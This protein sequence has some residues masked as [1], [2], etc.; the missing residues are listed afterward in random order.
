MSL[1]EVGAFAKT[2]ALTVKPDPLSGSHSNTFL[3]CTK[4]NKFSP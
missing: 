2:V 3:L 4:A 1:E